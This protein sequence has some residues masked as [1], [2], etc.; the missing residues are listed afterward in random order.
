MIPPGSARAS[1]DDDVAD[2]DADSKLDALFDRYIGVA[3]RHASLDIDGAAY[4]INHANELHQNSITGR[5]DDATAMLGELRINQFF[6]VKLEIAK[7]PLFVRPHQTAVT[8]NVTGQ[9]RGKSALD[10]ILRHRKSTWSQG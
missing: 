3:F 10:S 1:V 6:A 7:G 4:G 9:D 8:S 2:I 5:L